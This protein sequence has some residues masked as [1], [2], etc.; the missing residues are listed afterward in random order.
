[1][2]GRLEKVTRYKALDSVKEEELFVKQRDIW[3]RF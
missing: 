2:I 3:L 1:M